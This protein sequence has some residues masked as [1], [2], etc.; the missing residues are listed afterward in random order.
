[1]AVAYLVEAARTPVGKKSGSY[2]AL[3]LRDDVRMRRSGQRHHRRAS[4]T[5]ATSLRL[6]PGLNSQVCRLVRLDRTATGSTRR[7]FGFVD[8]C[9]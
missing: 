8:A 1:M 2:S 6:S 7:V 3:R 4:V 5:S 9:F